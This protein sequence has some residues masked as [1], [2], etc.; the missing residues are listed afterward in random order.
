VGRLPKPFAGLQTMGQS[1]EPPAAS[2]SAPERKSQQQGQSPPLLRRLRARTVAA[3]VAPAPENQSHGQSSSLLRR[4]GKPGAPPAA[5]AS[6]PQR[7]SLEH[8]HHTSTNE[9]RWRDV[10]TPHGSEAAR[11]AVG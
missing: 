9:S 8:E 3:A 2:T 7:K 5:C 10:L 11:G 6:E 4:L 1:P